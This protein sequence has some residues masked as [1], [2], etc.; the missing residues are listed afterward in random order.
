VNSRRTP[1]RAAIWLLQHFLRGHNT[2]AIIGD[3]HER[4][5]AGQSATWYWRQASRA[6]A[7]RFLSDLRQER[8]L[9]FRG[10]L[11]AFVV[12]VPL[13][14]VTL[15]VHRACLRAW[16]EPYARESSTVFAVWY[17]YQVPLLFMWVA[18]AVISGWFAVRFA[19][20][21]LMVVA[22]LAAILQLPLVAW[23]TWP[24]W[25]AANANSHVPQHSVPMRVMVFVA[26]IEIPIGTLLGGFLASRKHQSRACPPSD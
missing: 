25:I 17:L 26:L 21:D 11:A 8:L 14:Y 2:E 3:L 16:V 24:T 13:Y 22:S 15:D 7:G 5:S 18:T 1:P 6:I 12:L 4:Y 19:R 9:A 20:S 23:W 10:V